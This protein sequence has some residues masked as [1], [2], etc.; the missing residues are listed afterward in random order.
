MADRLLEDAAVQRV[1]VGP[2][3]AVLRGRAPG[4]TGYLITAAGRRGTAVGLL[5]VKPWKG[6]GLPGGSAPDGEKMRF[7]TRLEGARV[8]AIGPRRILLLKGEARF[9]LEAGVGEGA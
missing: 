6:A 3:A 9:A 7:R 5:A 2:L 4:G 1:D 8:E